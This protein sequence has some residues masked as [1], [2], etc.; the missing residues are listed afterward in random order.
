MLYSSFQELNMLTAILHRKR[1]AAE[2]AAKAAKLGAHTA[3]EALEA[4][5]RV[6][7]VRLLIAGLLWGSV[8]LIARGLLSLEIGT[9]LVRAAIA[10][11][12]I[13]FFIAYLWTWMNRLTEMDELER[14]IELEALGFAFPA[15][16]VLLMA[17][18]LL[19]IA[20]TLNPDDFSVRQLW[21]MLPLMYYIG[22]WRAKRRYQ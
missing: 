10:L 17:L 19:D 1:K 2:A 3:G 6:Y 22:L 4:N 21:F 20:I 7:G 15:T 13:P 11:L 9:P 16:L 5:R 14:R 12:P 18:G 8:Y